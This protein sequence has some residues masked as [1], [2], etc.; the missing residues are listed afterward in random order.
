M[1]INFFCKFYIGD[2]YRLKRHYS[3]DFSMK[4]GCDRYGINSALSD[5]YLTALH[6]LDQENNCIMCEKNIGNFSW[7]AKLK[8]NIIKNFYTCLKHFLSFSGYDMDVEACMDLHSTL[9]K[10]EMYWNL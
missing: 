4:P 1:L 7:I 5:Q 3:F 2:R 8:I 6:N 10:I 9:N